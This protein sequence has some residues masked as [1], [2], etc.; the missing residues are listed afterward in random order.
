[1]RWLPLLTV[2]VDD[3]SKDAPGE[4]DGTP[5]RWLP[6]VERLE[7]YVLMS[8]YTVINTADH[9]GTGF[10]GSFRYCWNQIAQTKV[11]GEID[12]AI[13]TSDANYN[14][15]KNTWTISLTQDPPASNS[16]KMLTMDTQVTVNGWT[17]GDTNGV[18]NYRGDR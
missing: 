8:T 11:P 2:L 4:C 17:Q 18:T 16:G 3:D 14:A 13:P 10:S 9:G 5:R 15:T 7:D 6:A 1:M 12:F